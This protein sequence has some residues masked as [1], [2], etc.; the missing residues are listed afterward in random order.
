MEN[1]N[2]ENGNDKILNSDCKKH[3]FPIFKDLFS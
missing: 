1:C 2:E 3:L